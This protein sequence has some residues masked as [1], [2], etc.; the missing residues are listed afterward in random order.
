MALEVPLCLAALG[1]GGGGWG[2]QPLA[3]LPF[4][5]LVSVET[6]GGWGGGVWRR[7]PGYP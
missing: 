3:L 4:L 6:G 2:S 5:C 1:V 7:A